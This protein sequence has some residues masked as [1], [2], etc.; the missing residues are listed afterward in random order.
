MLYK[1][2]VNILT[3]N[4]SKDISKSIFRICGFVTSCHV[5]KCPLG[6]YRKRK[7]NI[8]NL[9]WVVQKMDSAIHWIN[10]YPEGSIWETN[11]SIHWIEIYPV[12]NVIQLLNNRGQYDN[13]WVLVSAPSCNHFGR[14]GKEKKI[15]VTKITVNDT[16]L[17]SWFLAVKSQAVFFISCINGLSLH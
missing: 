3:V 1:F 8:Y 17:A 15:L 14:Q 5:T 6:L 9:A 12:D 4:S 16:N 13:S 2:L 10:H 11:C 7:K